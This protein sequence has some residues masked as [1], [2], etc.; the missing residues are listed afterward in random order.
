MCG[1]NIWSISWDCVSTSCDVHAPIL[2]TR[3]FNQIKIPFNIYTHKYFL[4]GTLNALARK[5]PSLHE[6]KKTRTH[7]VCACAVCQPNCNNQLINRT[8]SAFILQIDFFRLVFLFLHVAYDNDKHRNKYFSTLFTF[9]SYKSRCAV[10]VSL[11]CL[12][13]CLSSFSLCFFFLLF[14]FHSEFFAYHFFARIL[15]NARERACTYMTRN[16]GTKLWYKIM[17]RIALR[18]KSSLFSCGFLRNFFFSV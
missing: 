15:L 16:Y 10:S 17:L 11:S 12:C 2:N 14:V 1:Q 13:R 4:N 6:G 7:A 5:K 18:L 8:K 9:L 3:I